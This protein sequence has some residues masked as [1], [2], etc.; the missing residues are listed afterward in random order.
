[1]KIQTSPQKSRAMAVKR[2]L[3]AFTLVELIVVITIITILL[4]VGALGLKNL[5]KG[6]G[7]S[8]GVPVAEAVFAEARAIA[9]GKGTNTRV[10]IHA[11][12]DSDDEFHKERYLRYMAIQYEELNADGKPSGNWLL[13]SRGT[14]LPDAVYFMKD[15]SEINAPVLQTETVTLPGNSSTTCYYYQFNSEGLITS[16]TISGNSVPRFVIQVAS[17]PP[18]QSTPVASSDA[19]R[20]MGGFV[21]WRGGRT[22]LFRHPDQIEN[23]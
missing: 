5:S 8:A 18:G 17:L 1:M 15:L 6:S 11:E 22:S 20:N 10:L 4:T 19:K 16:P 7:I 12:L 3:P 14:T 21:I 2:R 9:I 23:N 13:A